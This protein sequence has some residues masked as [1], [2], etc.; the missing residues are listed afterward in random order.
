[1]Q[2]IVVITIFAHPTPTHTMLQMFFGF[3]FANICFKSRLET[4][5]DQDMTLNASMCW[6]LYKQN[7]EDWEESS[8]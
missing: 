2:N 8:F 5:F 1:M 7:E 6:L 3:T 4:E